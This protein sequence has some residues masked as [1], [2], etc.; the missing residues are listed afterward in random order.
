MIQDIFGD[1]DDDMAPTPIHRSVGDIVP[2]RSGDVAPT[3]IPRSGGDIV[4]S[5][6]GSIVPSSILDYVPLPRRLHRTPN[7]FPPRPMVPTPI[8]RRFGNT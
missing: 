7:P 1:S 2:S 3:P 4:P 5:R 8:P 6:F